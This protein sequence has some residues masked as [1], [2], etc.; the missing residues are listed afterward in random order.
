MTEHVRKE[1]YAVS[2]SIGKKLRCDFD[3]D[4]DV[5]TDVQH[6]LPRYEMR[7]KLL[8]SLASLSP[9]STKASSERVGSPRKSKSLF[10]PIL[11]QPVSL[12]PADPGQ[13]KP[14]NEPAL[15]IN[16]T[17]STRLYLESPPYKRPTP[18]L[19]GNAGAQFRLLEKGRSVDGDI[20]RRN[21]DWMSWEESTFGFV[22]MK[23]KDFMDYYEY[24]VFQLKLK[25]KEV[26]LKTLVTDSSKVYAEMSLDE[27]K[28]RFHLSSQSSTNQITIKPRS[29]LKKTSV[30][31][32]LNQRSCS[33]EQ[34]ALKPQTKDKKV[35]FSSNYLVLHYSPS[36]VSAGS[37]T[38]SVKPRKKSAFS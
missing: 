24:R 1:G 5:D 19:L 3:M 8:G 18:R 11:L 30:D 38:G 27:F 35:I 15:E 14:E 7:P 4:S 31:N 17:L 25:N 32:L 2:D 10:V 16:K 26:D 22:S 36:P 12:T 33:I 29:I 6:S 28:S 37:S 20:I 23:L 21:S 13:S 9:T 34:G